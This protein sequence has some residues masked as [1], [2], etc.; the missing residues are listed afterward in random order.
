MFSTS[1]E[2][3]KKKAHRLRCALMSLDDD[4]ENNVKE[5]VL[6]FILDVKTQ[7]SLM[8]LYS[9]AVQP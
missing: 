7:W 1:Q 4:A 3:K 2:K 8:H 6:M 9:T 5:S